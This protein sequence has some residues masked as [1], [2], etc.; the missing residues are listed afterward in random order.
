MSPVIDE[1]AMIQIPAD[2]LNLFRLKRYG[3]TGRGRVRH[4]TTGNFMAQG[5]DPCRVHAH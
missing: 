4:Q 2:L 5:V 1:P 3:R